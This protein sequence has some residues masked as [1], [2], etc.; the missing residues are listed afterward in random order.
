[1]TETTH[2]PSTGSCT[3]SRCILTVIT[4]ALLLVCIAAWMTYATALMP[5]LA[6]A[7]FLTGIISGS[8]FLLFFI[9]QIVG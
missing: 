2:T 1:M 8:L 4:W 9:A 5:A 6:S 3:R 7:L